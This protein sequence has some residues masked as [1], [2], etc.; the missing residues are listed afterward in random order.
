MSP[1]VRQTD[2]GDL[3]LRGR[4]K[5]RDIYDLG[6][7]LLIVATDRVS[8][9]DVVLPDPI[10]DKGTVLNQIS[11]FWFET[12]EEIVPNH[13]ISTS[14]EQ[15]PRECRK[16]RDHIEGRA[17]LV[18]KARPLPVECVVRGYLSGS[19]WKEY[20]KTGGVCGIRLPS[21]LV[22]SSRLEEPIFTP[23]TKEELGAH[24]VNISFEGM[25]D[26]IGRKLAEKV[27]QLSIEIYKEASALAD[28]RGIIIA[29]TKFEFGLLGKTLVLI[30]EVLTPDSSRFWPKDEYEPGRPQRSFDKQFL[31][32]YLL[33]LDWDRSSPGPKLPGE[34]IEKTRERYLEAYQR[35]VGE[36]LL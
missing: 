12:T 23:A 11:R 36:P 15:F 29:D 6:D 19:G 31:R 18:R 7:E 33:T 24:D 9:F 2:F 3:K 1:V 20:Q 22:E 16:Y 10:P 21:G 32:D 28:R 30:D 26:R 34:V 17:M 8:A 13:M 27:R 25:V 5:V 4:G 14:V 35:L